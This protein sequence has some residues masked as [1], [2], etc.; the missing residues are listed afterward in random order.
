[1]CVFGPGIREACRLCKSVLNSP[2]YEGGV[3]A[4]SADGVVLL[5]EPGEVSTGFFQ[6]CML[7]VATARRIATS[8][9]AWWIARQDYQPVSTGLPIGG[10]SQKKKGR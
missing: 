6:T 1:M 7:D 4:V 2:P 3:A 10:L 9:T 5:S 8:F